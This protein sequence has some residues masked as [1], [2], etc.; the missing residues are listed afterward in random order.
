MKTWGALLVSSVLGISGLS[1]PSA[2]AHAALESTS[3]AKGATVSKNTRQV[4]MVFGE[5]IL[6]LKDKNPN[7]LV[8]TD[9]QGKKVNKGNSV[10]SGTKIS[11]ALSYP[12]KMG[13]YTVRYRVVSEDGH[14]V[15]GTYTFIVK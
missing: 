11:S 4:S 8:V 14:V 9:A 5:N 2:E 6:V 7:S 1:S 12:L 10:I 3:P 15:S 13:K